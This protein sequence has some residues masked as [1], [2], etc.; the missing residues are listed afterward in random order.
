MAC[1]LQSHPA[2]G[3]RPEERTRDHPRNER[4]DKWELVLEPAAVE[5]EGSLIF[6]DF[7]LVHRHDPERRWLL[8]IAGFWTPG[9][10][11]TKLARLRAAGLTPIAGWSPTNRDRYAGAL[12]KE[13]VVQGQRGEVA[14]RG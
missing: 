5:A 12:R 13:E 6:P 7:A 2:E 1:G 11:E 8:E 4:A 3:T 14:R 10:L 9:Y